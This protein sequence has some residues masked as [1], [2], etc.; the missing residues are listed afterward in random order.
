MSYSNWKYKSKMHYVVLNLGNSYANGIHQNKDK[1]QNL[2][3]WLMWWL[4]W[5]RNKLGQSWAKLS[6]GLAYNVDC[7]DEGTKI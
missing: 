1:E 4:G 2:G 5:R 6:T 3:A 7:Y